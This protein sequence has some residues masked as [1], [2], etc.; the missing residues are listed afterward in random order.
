MES[1]SYPCVRF[2]ELNNY[3]L[4]PCINVDLK[5]PLLN[6]NGTTIRRTYPQLAQVLGRAMDCVR[7]VL[8]QCKDS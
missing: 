4:L 3:I 6:S 5:E 1:N 8:W 2:K 7:L